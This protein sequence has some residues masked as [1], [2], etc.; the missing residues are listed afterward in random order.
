MICM[1]ESMI[2]NPFFIADPLSK[3]RRFDSSNYNYPGG[4]V[5]GIA[6]ACASAFP[7]RHQALMTPAGSLTGEVD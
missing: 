7:V 6:L 2:L 5:N 1:S 3:Y 4:P